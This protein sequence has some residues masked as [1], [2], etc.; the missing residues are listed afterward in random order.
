MRRGFQLGLILGVAV[1][2]L[3]FAGLGFLIAINA[4]ARL[5]ACGPSC[6][7]IPTALNSTQRD[8]GLTWGWLGVGLASAAFVVLQ[9]MRVRE[10][11]A[12]RSPNT[13]PP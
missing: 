6:S 11:R 5:R 8:Y 12:S 10:R 9:V 13:P 1:V 2:G 7:P 3:I 4:E